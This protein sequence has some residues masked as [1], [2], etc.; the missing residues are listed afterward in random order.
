ML[1]ADRPVRRTFLL[2]TVAAIALQFGYYG[3]NSWLP[4]Y[5]VKDLNV[6]VQSMGW[7]V[8]GTYTMMVIGKIV[9]G[10]L[11]DIAGRRVMWVVS[12]V[13][14]AAYLPVLLVWRT[15]R[16]QLDVPERELPGGRS[17]N[18]GRDVV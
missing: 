2:W 17:R 5:L 13:L 1:W 9:T 3:A 8:A 6:N 18:R 14:T 7:Y 10:Y 11:A 12:G 16:D 4:S 15:I